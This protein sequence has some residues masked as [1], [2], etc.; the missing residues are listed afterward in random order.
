MNLIILL[1]FHVNFIE[2]K[3]TLISSEFNSDDFILTPTST[4]GWIIS[5]PPGY[6]PALPA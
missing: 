3:W 1:S 5:L 2:C 4:N 6:S